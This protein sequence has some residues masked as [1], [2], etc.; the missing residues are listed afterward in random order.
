MISGGG[1]GDVATR[2]WGMNK[3]WL[4]L[5]LE[6]GSR[7]AELRKE[8]GRS[9]PGNGHDDSF[10]FFVTPPPTPPFM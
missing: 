9:R 1:S 5:A 8:G 6:E 2:I 4:I 3:R 10:P 7:R